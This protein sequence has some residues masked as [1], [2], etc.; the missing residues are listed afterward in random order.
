[1]DVYERE[2]QRGTD[3]EM[4]RPDW[5]NERNLLS[6][7]RISAEVRI[8]AVKS[9]LLGGPPSGFEAVLAAS[10]TVLQWRDTPGSTGPA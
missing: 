6:P 3:Y 5:K 9:S 10:S 7:R 1:M 4:K 8:A 2:G